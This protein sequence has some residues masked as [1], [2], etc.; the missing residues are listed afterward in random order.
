MITPPV[1]P[2]RLNIFERYLSLW[3]GLCMGAGLGERPADAGAVRA[4][5]HRRGGAHRSAGHAL[6]LRRVQSHAS[7]VPGAGRRAVTGVLSVD[8]K[9]QKRLKALID[10]GQLGGQ[11]LS[12]DSSDAALVDRSQ[13]ID[14]RVR[15]LRQA[16]GTRRQPWVE[17]AVARRAGDWNHGDKRE[18]VVSR[19]R[20][21]PIP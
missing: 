6:G 18:S 2:K 3:V 11:D 13:V 10:A 12:E 14:E 7:L 20:V 8:T 15:C 9:A 19:L 21:T 1:A 17:R 16:A 5:R 4:D